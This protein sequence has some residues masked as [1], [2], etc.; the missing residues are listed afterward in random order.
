MRCLGA[1]KSD[2]RRALAGGGFGC[3]LRNDG[4][5]DGTSRPGVSGRERGAARG[6]HQAVRQT[7][8]AGFALWLPHGRDAATTHGLY[9]GWRAGVR[10]RLGAAAPGPSAAGT[11]HHGR[12]S[13][14]VSG[15]QQARGQ[16]AEAAAVTGVAAMAATGRLRES[17]GVSCRLRQRVR[18]P[19]TAP[20]RAARAPGAGSQKA[21]RQ[22]GP[23]RGRKEARVGPLW[24]GSQRQPN[25]RNAPPT[26]AGRRV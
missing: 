21:R 3:V 9:C 10:R 12:E 19:G 16:A 14:G 15:S 1:A 7:G 17:E 4:A 23:L 13:A 18:P 6:Q 2:Q 20:A 25:A 5:A 11:R 8:P 24:R 22:H 26:G